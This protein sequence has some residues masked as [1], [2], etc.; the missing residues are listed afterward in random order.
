M[1]K[2]Y[3]DCA[4]TVYDSHLDTGDLVNGGM[5]LAAVFASSDEAD[6]I[7]AKYR[8]DNRYDV[9]PSGAGAIGDAAMQ[10]AKRYQDSN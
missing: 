1:S 2:K 9:R 10:I 6:S 4:Y 3:W 5:I 7:L 8:A